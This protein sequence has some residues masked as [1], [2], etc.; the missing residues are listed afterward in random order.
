MYGTST[1]FGFAVDIT[2]APPPPRV[3]FVSEPRLEPVSG[4][5]YIV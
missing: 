5:V 2:N 1:T 3:V 4:S